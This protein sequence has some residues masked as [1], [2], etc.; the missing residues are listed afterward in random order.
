M[1]EQHYLIFCLCGGATIMKNIF[2]EKSS[3]KQTFYSVFAAFI[4]VQSNKNRHR[5]FNQG[6]LSHFIMGGIIAVL[7]FISVLVL[8]VNLVIPS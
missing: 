1:L 4:G 8:V 6:K 2:E 7:L 5:D 3:L